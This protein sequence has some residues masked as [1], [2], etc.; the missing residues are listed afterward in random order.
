MKLL[1]SLAIP[2]MFPAIEKLKK[3]GILRTLCFGD[4]STGGKRSAT[5]F[6]NHPLAVK[7]SEP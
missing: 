2:T 4:I 3:R 1:L 7:R 5:K 6:I